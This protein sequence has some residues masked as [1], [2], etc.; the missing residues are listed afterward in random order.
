MKKQLKEY[1]YILLGFRVNFLEPEPSL[2]IIEDYI[3]YRGWKIVK[4]SAGIHEASKHKHYHYHLIVEPTAVKLY[5]TGE[6]YAFKKYLREVGQWDQLKGNHSVKDEKIKLEEG[7]EDIESAENRFLRY[8]L[9]EGTP[10][11]NYC[12][13]INLDLLMQTA[14]AQFQHLKEKI[15]ADQ[16]KDENNKLKW[17]TL[18]RHLDTKKPTTYIQVFTELIE[19]TRLENPPVTTKLINTKTINYMKQKKLLTD[20]EIIYIENYGTKWILQKQDKM[21]MSQ[22]LGEKI[23]EKLDNGQEISQ[24][25]IIKYYNSL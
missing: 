23:F 9:K 21:T 5:S 10:L 1:P 7:D 19:Y 4:S 20:L 17:N 8:P 18:C 16:L 12:V 24:N 15:Q 25:E 2:K 13:N 11:E 14:V 3:K 22:D 6:A